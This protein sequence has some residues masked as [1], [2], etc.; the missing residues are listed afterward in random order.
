MAFSNS[1]WSALSSD[2][3]LALSLTSS[4]SFLK[5]HLLNEANLDHHILNCK[6]FSTLPIPLILLYFFFLPQ[7]L[8]IH[9]SVFI[10]YSVFSLQEYQLNEWGIFVWKRVEHM[11]IQADLGI[12]R[13]LRRFLIFL[14]AYSLVDRWH[15]NT[16][17]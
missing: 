8:Q 9:L 2:L 13:I 12:Q 10:V 5:C 7:S 3:P 14:C 11:G 16:Q 1:A 17:R 4:K 15:V 6:S